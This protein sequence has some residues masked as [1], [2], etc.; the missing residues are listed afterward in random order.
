MIYITLWQYF[1]K[2][3]GL[4]TRL[5]TTCYLMSEH[6]K[7]EIEQ[8]YIYSQSY[9][10]KLYDIIEKINSFRGL[11][12]VANSSL[13]TRWHYES[14]SEFKAHQYKTAIVFPDI[15]LTQRQTSLLL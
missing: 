15:C 6:F 12:K 2:Y 1:I 7:L 5:N 11:Y 3:T 14:T 9:S 13:F 10:F 8:K 4:F